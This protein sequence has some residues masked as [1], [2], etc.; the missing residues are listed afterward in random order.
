MNKGKTDETVMENKVSINI[1]FIGSLA[2]DFGYMNPLR[3]KDMID[4]RNY[5]ESI[6]KL[7]NVTVAATWRDIIKDQHYLM[8][9]DFNDVVKYCINLFTAIEKKYPRT[10]KG[11][12]QAFKNLP[13][14]KKNDARGLNSYSVRGNH[15]FPE[16][17]DL[18]DALKLQTIVDDD[19]ETTSA[20]KSTESATW[21][22]SANTWESYNKSV[23]VLNMELENS[24][25]KP[26]NNTP[27]TGQATVTDCS[28]IHL[29]ALV[30]RFH[31]YVIYGN[32]TEMQLFTHSK[33]SSDA[34]PYDSTFEN[35]YIYYFFSNDLI[36]KIRK[37]KN[38]YITLRFYCYPDQRPVTATLDIHPY[39][40]EKYMAD[41]IVKV[42]EDAESVMYH[43]VESSFYYNDTE[44]YYEL[45]VPTS[46]FV[47]AKT[48]K[49]IRLRS[50][51]FYE[52]VNLTNKCVV[53]Y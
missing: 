6:A 39:S 19:S 4:L 16:W 20:I 33:V 28:E 49:G 37:S 21:S 3:H 27:E 17:D 40:S 52:Y 41:N 48:F 7:Y 12:I 36:S 5:L 22:T 25:E 30:N 53:I 11:D 23:K 47:D 13:T 9:R 44:R 51:T 15:Y 14:I 46:S 24:N 26:N 42:N 34:K 8:A 31:K 38:E 18:I 2:I 43:S 29:T 35:Y 10:F 32:S 50:L 1:S 45:K